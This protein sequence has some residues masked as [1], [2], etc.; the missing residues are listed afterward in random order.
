ML[1]FI[2][3]VRQDRHRS[4]VKIPGCID[5]RIEICMGLDEEWEKGMA[6]Q[7]SPAL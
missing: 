6:N 3:C 7:A 2:S 1:L 4:P 5:G